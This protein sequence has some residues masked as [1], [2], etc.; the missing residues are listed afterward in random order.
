M[1]ASLRAKRQQ[2]VEDYARNNPLI[3]LCV[4]CVERGDFTLEEAALTA[5]MMLANVN[6]DLMD[7]LAG[8]FPT[9]YLIVTKE[10][11]DALSAQTP[12]PSANPRAQPTDAGHDDP[13]AQG[14]A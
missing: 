9:Q 13:D 10:Q 5:A 1:N 8:G 4:R 6:R 11:Y 2:F 12:F 14:S 7:R 3:A